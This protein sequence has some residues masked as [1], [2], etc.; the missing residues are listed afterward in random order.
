MSSNVADIDLVAFGAFPKPIQSASIIK[1]I[2]QKEA[3]SVQLRS[4]AV[5]IEVK[6]HDARFVKVDANRVYVRY[7][8]GWSDATGQSIRQRE[9]L[10]EFLTSNLGSSPYIVNLLWL[11]NCRQDQLRHLRLPEPNNVLSSD[12]CWDT[13]LSTLFNLN[14]PR[15]AS[16]GFSYGVPASAFVNLQGAIRLLTSSIEATTLDRKRI[17]QI[18]R[19]Q[20]DLSPVDNIGAGIR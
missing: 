12:V 14:P 13:F 2:N 8:S 18:T 3:T 6:D 7:S 16:E 15:P 1:S 11:R 17:E 4:F 10:R 9:A 19:E 5:T 20:L